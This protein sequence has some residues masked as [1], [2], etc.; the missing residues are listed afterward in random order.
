MSEIK[1]K[2]LR[3]RNA[4]NYVPNEV[5][6]NDCGLNTFYKTEAKAKSRRDWCNAKYAPKKYVVAGCTECCGFHVKEIKP[7]WDLVEVESEDERKAF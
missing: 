4:K 1:T 6:I 3:I 2:P 7:V 5:T